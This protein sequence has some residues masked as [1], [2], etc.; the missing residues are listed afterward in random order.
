NR[1]P[2]AAASPAAVPV[3]RYGA[4]AAPTESADE[5]NGPTRGPEKR[6]KSCSG[7][8]SVDGLQYFLQTG[9]GAA[10]IAQIGRQQQC[11]GLLR[12]FLEGAHVLFGDAQADG[13]LATVF[14]HRRGHL[15][16]TGGGGLGD[17][18]DLPGATFRLVDLLHLFTFGDVDHLLL[19]TLGAV[20][21]RLAVTLGTVDRGLT[22]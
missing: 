21:R 14:L 2:P 17:Q 8:G 3:L 11:G 7:L 19:L 22:I 9:D 1:H 4:T 12:Q 18:F 16:Q 10:D 15:T 20:D 5:G 6:R 13:F